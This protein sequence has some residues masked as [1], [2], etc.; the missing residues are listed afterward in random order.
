MR[1]TVERGDRH[2][3]HSFQRK[4][5][6]GSKNNHSST[7]YVGRGTKLGELLEKS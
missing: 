4:S 7:F 1:G 3:N 2:R 5:F 6:G